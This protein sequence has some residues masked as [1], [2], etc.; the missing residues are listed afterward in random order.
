MELE[1]IASFC[2]FRDCEISIGDPDTG[3]VQIDGNGLKRNTYTY[4]RFN[5]L[6][7]VAHL[8]SPKRVLSQASVFRVKRGATENTLT[9]EEFL[10]ELEHFQKLVSA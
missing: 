5:M 6:T 9:R 8:A 3:F 4:G 7:E 1:E 10:S 2:E